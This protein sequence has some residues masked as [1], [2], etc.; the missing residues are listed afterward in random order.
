MPYVEAYDPVTHQWS[1]LAKLP[2]F[3]KSE[4]AVAA[5]RN[6]II[7]SGGRIHSKDVWL[8]QVKK[9][10]IFETFSMICGPFSHTWTTGSKW[11]VWSGADGVIE[12]TRWAGTFIVLE[13]L[14]AKAN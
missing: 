8:Y 2:A 7:V 4:Y 6:S 10:E 5:Y 14:M 9:F 11:R 1:A 13:V 12:C 3:T